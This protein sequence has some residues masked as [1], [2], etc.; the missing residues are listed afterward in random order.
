MARTYGY[1]ILGGMIATFTVSPALSAILLPD[2]VGAI[3]TWLT[4]TLRRLYHPLLQFA[5]SNRIVVL[6]GV[7]VLG[8]AAVVAARSLGV[9]FLPSLEEGNLWIRATMPV[10]ISLQEA[11]PY[12]DRMRWIIGSFP[13]V[14]TVTSQ[15][16]R[17]DSGT[18]AIGPFLAKLYVPLK[19][20]SEWPAGVDKRNLVHAIDS[21]L[22]ARLPGVDFSFSQYISNNID[23][24]LTGTKSANA[25]KIFGHNLATLERLG[26]EIKKA[27]ATVGGVTDLN[28]PRAGGQPTVEIRINRRQAARYGLSPGTINDTIARPSAAKQSDASMSAAATATSRSSCGSPRATERAYRRCAASWSRRRA[29]AAAVSRS[30]FPTL[31]R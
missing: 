27:M 5:L 11:K 28:M 4:R 19:P 14:A 7:A 25:V 31:P 21:A 26:D 30:R 13:E 2:K 17:P 6:G 20:S 1:A 16:G 3:E 10:S 24:I 18:D 23:E 22:K 12:V 8:L 15:D 9:E 29:P